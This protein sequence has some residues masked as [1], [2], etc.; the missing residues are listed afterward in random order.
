MP[1]P[2]TAPR[3]ARA[4]AQLRLFRLE[5]MRAGLHDVV[6]PDCNAA[7]VAARTCDQLKPELRNYE[8]S[9]RAERSGSDVAVHGSIGNAY[10]LCADADDC[11][12]PLGCTL[13]TNTCSACASDA[14]CDRG[15]G[16]YIYS[17][18][19]ECLQGR[20]LERRRLHRQS[21]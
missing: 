4:R 13:S 5:T 1:A 15:F 7:S 2:I 20:L 11:E 9:A 3:C 16:S 17:A 21:V 6:A 12:L 19:K 14:D 8:D 18:E 10:G